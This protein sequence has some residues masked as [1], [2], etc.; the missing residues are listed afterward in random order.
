MTSLGDMESTWLASITLFWLLPF[1]HLSTTQGS[2]TMGFVVVKLLDSLIGRTC[3]AFESHYYAL[4][5]YEGTEASFK[6]SFLFSL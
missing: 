1:I 6:L 5:S 4:G 3:R 2:A